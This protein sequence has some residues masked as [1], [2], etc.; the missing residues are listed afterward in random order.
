MAPTW[1]IYRVVLLVSE[2]ETRPTETDE[3]VFTAKVD[4]SLYDTSRGLL[5][6]VAQ[7]LWV[8]HQS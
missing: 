5:V 7:T 8:N 1:P 6:R 3:Y 2:T 4:Q